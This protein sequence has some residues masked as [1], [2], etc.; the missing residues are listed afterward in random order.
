MYSRCI[1]HTNLN[2]PG[3]S[4]MLNGLR[5]LQAWFE[6]PTRPNSIVR[7]SSKSGPRARR[8]FLCVDDQVRICVVLRESTFEITEPFHGT[9]RS[10]L[11]TGTAMTITVPVRHILRAVGFENDHVRDLSKPERTPHKPLISS[12]MQALGWT[13][14]FDLDAG[15]TT[16]QAT[17]RS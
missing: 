16:F 2:G 3:A 9:P 14:N 8:R 17:C 12:R 1:M 13:A 15:I 6:H 4:Y 10:N 7:G 11:R 5:V